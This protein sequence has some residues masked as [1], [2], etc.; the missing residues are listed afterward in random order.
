MAMETVVVMLTGV[1]V[2]VVFMVT[3]VAMVT[4]VMQRCHPLELFMRNNPKKGGNGAA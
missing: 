2:T 3:V 1:I 4:V